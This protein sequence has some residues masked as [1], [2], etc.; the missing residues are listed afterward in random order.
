VVS[1]CNCAKEGAFGGIY[2]KNEMEK[3]IR[4]GE[5]KRKKKKGMLIWNKNQRNQKDDQ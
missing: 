2:L 1:I 3:K 4:K 5:K